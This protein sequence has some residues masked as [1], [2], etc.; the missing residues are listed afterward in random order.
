MEPSQEIGRPAF[1]AFYG[2]SLNSWRQPG[3]TLTS[4]SISLGLVRLLGRGRDKPV[5]TDRKKLA[6]SLG[7]LT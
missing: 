3:C 6:P 2:G 7:E 1:V 5:T 4:L